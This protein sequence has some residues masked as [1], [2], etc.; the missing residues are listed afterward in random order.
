VFFLLYLLLIF[1]IGS[2]ISGLWLG[3]NGADEYGVGDAAVDVAVEFVGFFFV[4]GEGG[5]GGGAG[6][7]DDGVDVVMD[8]VNV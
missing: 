5:D 8:C 3:G 2:C 6:G 1:F 7:F 4:G